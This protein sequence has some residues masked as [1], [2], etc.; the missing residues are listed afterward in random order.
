MLAIER[1][2][3]IL[4]KLQAE[5]RV[6]VSELS[7]IYKVSEETIRRDLEKLENDGFVIKSY[8]GAVMKMQM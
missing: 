1:R 3:A 4:E 7:Q 5:R 2:N 8:G 6:V